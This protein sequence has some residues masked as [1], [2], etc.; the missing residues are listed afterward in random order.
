MAK[1]YIE[2]E[3]V[4]KFIENG[5]NNPDRAKA[6]GYDAVE[7]MAEVKYMDAADVV[8]RKR[9]EWISVKERLPENGETVLVYRPTMKTQYMTSYFWYRFCDGAIDIQGNDVITHWMPLPEPPATV[10]KNETVSKE[11]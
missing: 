11:V 4:L 1:E 7:I 9:G 2:R 6:F 5:L 10:A 8:E 3:A